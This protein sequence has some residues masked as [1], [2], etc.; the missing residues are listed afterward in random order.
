MAKG[1]DPIALDA[2]GA[3]ADADGAFH[4]VLLI[5]IRAEPAL[6]LALFRRASPFA[7][8]EIERHASLGALLADLHEET[9]ARLR[10]TS[11]LERIADRIRAVDDLRPA[12]AS[13]RDAPTLLD[14]AAQAIA[15]RFHADAASVM[16][17]D[18]N[19]ELRVR[20]SVGLSPQ[21]A[22]DARRRVGEGIAGWVAARRRGVL[23]RGPVDDGRFRGVD[24]EAGAALSVPLRIGDEVLGVLNVK[25]PREGAVFDESHL[26]VLEA[27][28]SDVAMAL[29]Q[30]EAVQRLDE[31]LRRAVAIAEIARLV[32]S[33]ERRVAARLA[34]EA[35]GYAAIAIETANGLEVLHAEDGASV[36]AQ[37][38]ARFDT[39]A[40]AVLFAP[41]PETQEEAVLIAERIAPILAGPAP[42]AEVRPGPLRSPGGLLRVF[43][44][45]DHPVVREGLRGVL[46]RDGDMSVC[47]SA[48]TLAEAVGAVLET[49]PGVIVCDLHLPDADDVEAVRRLASLAPR[50]PVVVFS[51]ESGMDVVAAALHAGARGY[52]PKRATAEQLRAA[53]RAAASGILA[54]HPDL[55]GALLV[56]PQSDPEQEPRRDTPAVPKEGLTPRELEYL[57]YLAEGYTNKEIARAMVLAEDTVKKGVQAL[58]AKLGAVDRTHAVVIALRGALI[59]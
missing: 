38:T 41:G 47:G 15:E 29:R 35:L 45:E 11:E 5:P 28:A 55:L 18:Q 39:P 37:G 22:R 34:C 57:R 48:Q 14:R 27:I 53:V 10:A 8:E 33:G 59:D 24:P 13:A 17:L 31:D 54:V 21:I 12:F 51:I 26:R 23:L 58:I 43:V 50:P 49:R 25:R 9:R 6:V 7:A 2:E 30:V 20:A 32:Q 16:L 42:A 52:V 4:G 3:V 36:R 1:G 44:V 40:G 56:H 46:E 19:G